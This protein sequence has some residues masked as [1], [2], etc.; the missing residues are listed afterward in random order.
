MLNWQ[1][2]A[3]VNM[4]VARRVLSALRWLQLSLFPYTRDEAAA[5]HLALLMVPQQDDAFTWQY[6]CLAALTRVGYRHS[7]DR[8]ARF[9]TLYKILNVAGPIRTNLIRSEG[10]LIGQPGA[11]NQHD[12]IT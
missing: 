9:A 8:R 5:V 3:K 7:R 6:L 4:P 10:R 11:A 1:V 2:A 12:Q